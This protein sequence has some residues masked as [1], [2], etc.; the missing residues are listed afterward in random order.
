MFSYLATQCSLV[1]V[2]PL[3]AIEACARLADGFT[4]SYPEHWMEMSDQLNVPIAL[5]T[6]KEPP[7][8]IA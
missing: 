7:V 5:T 6:D 4:H 3:Q 8:P 1:K 2:T